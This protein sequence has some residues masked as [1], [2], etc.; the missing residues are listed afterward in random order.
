MPMQSPAAQEFAKG[1][2]S[3]SSKRWQMVN[4]DASPRAQ[5]AH[6]LQQVRQEMPNATADETQQEAINRLNAQ[7]GLQQQQA[8]AEEARAMVPTVEAATS[9]YA[10]MTGAEAQQTAI[11]RVAESP[12]LQEL[13][14]QG[15]TGI[16]QSAAA[17]GG[18]RGG[19]T[20]A[21]LAQFRPAMLQQ[22][23]DKLYGRLQGISGMGQ[24]SILG[25][26]TTVVG[27]A[28]QMSYQSQI[29]GLLTQAGAAQAGGLLGQAQAQRDMFGDIG[30]AVGWGLEK[31]SQGGFAPWKPNTTTTPNYG[32]LGIGNPANY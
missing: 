14:A 5:A 19:R 2:L 29:P 25:A 31:Y 27:A 4:A 30:T 1:G 32:G 7:Y 23:I 24:S 6:T 12:L 21:A 28:P 11:Q 16:L 18:L 3:L 20:Q 15:E 8:A 22:E 17:T 26:P 10:G 9:P 13:M